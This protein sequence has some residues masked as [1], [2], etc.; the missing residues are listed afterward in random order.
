VRKL[1]QRTS[2]ATHA[3]GRV[4]GN[5][6]S[7]SASVTA[8]VSGVR[9]ELSHL[10]ERGLDARESLN[11]L[12]GVVTRLHELSQDS[13]RAVLIETEKVNLLAFL[14][15]VWLAIQGQGPGTPESFADHSTCRLGRW[16]DDGEGRRAFAHQPG[17]HEIDTPH[18]EM[19]RHAAAA[20]RLAQAG[21]MAAAMAE[22]SAMQAATT[23]LAAILDTLVAHQTADEGTF[24]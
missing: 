17:F 12:V 4:I 6:S 16:H 11:A 10:G 22:A 3:I 24:F 5:V 19:H 7:E 9:G 14:G 1:S 20:I 2:E 8:I 21:D 13:T 15:S 18:R 23:R